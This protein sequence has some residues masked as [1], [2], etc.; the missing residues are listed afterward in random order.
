MFVAPAGNIALKA[1]ERTATIHDVL[2]WD[3]LRAGAAH[4]TRKRDHPTIMDG[5][6]D[7]SRA[8]KSYVAPLEPAKANREIRLLADRFPPPHPGSFLGRTLKVVAMPT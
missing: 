4:A 7:A 3:L 6:I 8:A 2:A 1:A 5:S